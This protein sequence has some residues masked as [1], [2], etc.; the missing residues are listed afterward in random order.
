MFFEDKDQFVNLKQQNR[1]SANKK[2]SDEQNTPNKCKFP[3][4]LN[5]KWKN[6][7]NSRYVFNVNSNL[8]HVV[9]VNLNSKQKVNN[10]S[11]QH[12]KNKKYSNS[13]LKNQYSF[14]SIHLRLTCN[15]AL[16]DKDVSKEHLYLVNNL[17]EW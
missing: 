16:N 13:N 5:K 17:L 2:L 1:F 14:E 4:I 6:L 10:Q 11:S 15:E 9:Q 8:L 7:Q 12:F 3:K